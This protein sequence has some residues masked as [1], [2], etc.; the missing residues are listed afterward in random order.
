MRFVCSLRP[1]KQDWTASSCRHSLGLLAQNDQLI[2]AQRQHRV[3]I[4]H[5][6]TIIQPLRIVAV[7]FSVVE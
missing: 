6:Y 7:S 3:G 5:R 4:R 1:W 2:A